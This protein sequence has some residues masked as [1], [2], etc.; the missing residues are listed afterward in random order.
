MAIRYYE[1]E[2]LEFNLVTFVNLARILTFDKRWKQRPF[3][4]WFIVSVQ[5][6]RGVYFISHLS[7]GV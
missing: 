7:H 3:I 5:N 4:Y 2:A 1:P 6:G